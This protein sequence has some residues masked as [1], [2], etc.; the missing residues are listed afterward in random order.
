MYIHMYIYIYVYVYVYTY[1][2]IYIYMYTY[3]CIYTYEQTVEN[4]RKQLAQF[5]QI[6]SLLN[7]IYIQLFVVL[8]F[9]EISRRVR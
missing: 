4:N 6:I 1:I 9:E 5:S 3:I 2:D 7:L 8:T